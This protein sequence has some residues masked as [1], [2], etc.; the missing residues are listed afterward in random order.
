LPIAGIASIDFR[1]ISYHYH[2]YHI[3][4]IAVQIYIAGRAVNPCCVMSDDPPDYSVGYKKPPLHSRF[5]KGQSGNPEG[6]RLHR[7]RD[8]RLA[9]LLEE[10]LDAR[11]AARSRRPLTRRQAIVVGLVEKSAA[12][13]LRAV[14]LLLD[15]VLKTE[16]AA[17]P[18]GIGEDDPC[19]FL[20]R[21][22]NRLAAAPTTG[23]VK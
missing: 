14:K 7:R 8:V 9:A 10:A 19:A 5:Q 17:P 12:G 23:E 18:P 16:L 15:L 1:L 21:E 13:D 11:V 4:N 20:L 6:G 2:N 22:L 3:D